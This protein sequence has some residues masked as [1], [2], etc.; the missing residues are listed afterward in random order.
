[1]ALVY[2]ST[3][4]FCPQ[5]RSEYRPGFTHCT[6]CDVDLVNALPESK[7]ETSKALPGGSL[8][9]LWEGED[10]ALFKSLLDE[11]EAAGIRYFDQ[12]L[13]IYPGVR[14]RDHFP[15]QPLMRFGYQVAVLSPNLERARTVLERLQREKPRD[16]EI[17]ASD[18][19][20]VETQHRTA[21]P[22]GALTCE[23]WSGTDVSLAEFLE[24]AL[25]ENGISSRV[26]RRG[27]NATISISSADQG[28]A[29]DIVREIVEGAPP[30]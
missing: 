10:L 5:C 7:E 30:E 11:L 29:H 19:E 8:E 16:M 14:R 1:M 20:Q 6:D 4:M 15:V 2:T 13:S 18:E 9:I 25:K 3:T 28:A 23:L 12:A 17:P 27:E 21:Q 26:D 24:V 22:D